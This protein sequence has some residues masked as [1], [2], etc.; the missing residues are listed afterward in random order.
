MI[1]SCVRSD[2]FRF[3]RSWIAAPMRVASIAPS[4]PALARLITSEIGPVHAPVIELGP[5]TGVFTRALLARGVRE[6][7][8]T[9]VEFGEEFASLLRARFPQA[10][11]ASIDA[12]TL[13]AS[14]LFSEASAGAAVSGL[15]LLVMPE[16]KV[17]AIVAATFSCLRPGARLYQF[18]Y[19]PRCPVQPAILDRL[20]LA[21]VPIGRTVRNIPPATVYRFSRRDEDPRSGSEVMELPA[22]V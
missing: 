3:F 1:A 15:P 4:S 18:T 14:G 8:L 16:D 20:G 21:A 5:G 19:G 11:I 17:E 9:L 2:F 6:S 12:A 13:A 7:D 10:R 22:P